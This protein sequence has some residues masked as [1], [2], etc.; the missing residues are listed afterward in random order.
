MAR[1]VMEGVSFALYQ[2]MEVCRELGLTA[3]I[4]AANSAG[5][6]QGVAENP[7]GYL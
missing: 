6:E 5:K 2:C 7:G 4:A 3:E 1:A